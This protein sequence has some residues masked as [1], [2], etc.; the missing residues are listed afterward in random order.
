MVKIN[1]FLIKAML[2]KASMKWNKIKILTLNA[3]KKKFP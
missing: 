2:N 1:H 3:L